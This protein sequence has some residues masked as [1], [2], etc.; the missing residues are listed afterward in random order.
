VADA[1]FRQ[2]ILL[3]R[4]RNERM[5]ERQNASAPR[6]NG[7]FL[8]SIAKK[9][10]GRAQ[11]IGVPRTCA[12]TAAWKTRTA[13]EASASGHPRAIGRFAAAAFPGLRGT[14]FR[15]YPNFF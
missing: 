3:F 1:H 11:K 12:A 5:P 8:E 2:A 9:I 14:G 7:S 13:R 15:N 4:Q 10:S 6:G